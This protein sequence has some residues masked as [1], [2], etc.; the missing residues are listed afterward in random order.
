LLLLHLVACMSQLACFTDPSTSPHNYPP[1]PRLCGKPTNSQLLLDYLR[2][3][4]FGRQA[5]RSPNPQQQ[6]ER[7][8]VPPPLASP[9]IPHNLISPSPVP[10][11]PNPST[12]MSVAE[13]N[14][15]TSPSRKPPYFF[16]EE[17]A[18][19]VVKGN[20]MTLAATPRHVDKGEWLAHQ[21]R[22]LFV[23]RRRF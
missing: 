4:G 2:R 16:R 7:G 3:Q 23:C 22:L 9:V 17:Y 12:A 20:F 19:L 10:P 15:S 1:I 18:N 6:Q 8:H 5:N 13:S 11:S 14:S 21:S